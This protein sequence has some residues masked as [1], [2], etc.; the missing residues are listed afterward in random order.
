M[1]DLK[2]YYIYGRTNRSL[3]KPSIHIMSV[4]YIHDIKSYYLIETIQSKSILNSLYDYCTTH[5]IPVE[6]ND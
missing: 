2:P 4:T 5:N 6:T 3:S 1:S